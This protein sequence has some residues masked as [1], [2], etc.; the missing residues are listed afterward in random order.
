[1]ARLLEIG[2][3]RLDRV[4]LGKGSFAQVKLASHVLLGTKVAL[5]IT[6]TDQLKDAY[7]RKNLHREST[8]LG[9]L[10]HPHVVKLIEICTTKKIHCLALQYIPGAKN[11]YDIVTEN[12]ALTESFTLLICRQLVSALMYVH[13]KNILHRDLKMNNVLLDASFSHCLLIDFGLSNFWYPGQVMNT[14]CGSAEYA[15]PEL[16]K[17]VPMYGPGIDVWSFGILLF[18]MLFGQLPFQIEKDNLKCLINHIQRGLTEDHHRAMNK[19]LS[20]ECQLLISSCLDLNPITRITMTEIAR[21]SWVTGNGKETVKLINQTKKLSVQQEIARS[22]CDRLNLSLSIEKIIHH[23]TNRPFHTTGGCF[24]LLLQ[25][26]LEREQVASNIPVPKVEVQAGVSNTKPELPK[27]RILRQIE[28]LPIENRDTQKSKRLF[29][30]P[31]ETS[32]RQ[33]ECSQKT[34]KTVL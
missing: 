10:D 34:P 3:Y 16:F 1:M 23:V 28:N 7:I 32:E 17:R 4:T 24:N 30:Q 8:I 27:K 14:H 13:S 19:H 22:M 6:Y 12:G 15:A 11:L 2:N 26:Y 31:K 21:H 25:E 9:Q 18:G 33:A 20:V 5:K 29:I